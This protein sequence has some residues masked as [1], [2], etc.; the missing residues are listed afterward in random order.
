MT[1]IFTIPECCNKSMELKAS[2][3]NGGIVF[4]VFQCKKC[5]NVKEIEPNKRSLW[6]KINR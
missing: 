4:Y 1:K 3:C 5:S 6:E 2:Y